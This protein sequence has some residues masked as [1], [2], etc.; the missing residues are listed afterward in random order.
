MN[1]SYEIINKEFKIEFKNSKNKPTGEI[2][3]VSS[4]KWIAPEMLLVDFTPVS[5]CNL[6][7]SK[8]FN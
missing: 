3:S 5:H 4:F 7:Y 2:D 6:T 1:T 8:G